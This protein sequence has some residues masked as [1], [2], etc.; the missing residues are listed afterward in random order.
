MTRKLLPHL[1]PHLILLM[2]ICGFMAGEIR[3][4]RIVAWF[5]LLAVILDVFIDPHARNRAG[6]LADV[7]AGNSLVWTLL[8]WSMVPL[9]LA[10]VI[11]GLMLVTREQLTAYELVMVTVSIGFTGAMFSIPV[12]HELMHRTSW[13]DRASAVII[14]TMFSYT[15]FCIEHVYGHHRNVGTAEDTATARF[16]ESF[17]AFYHRAI[18]DGLI[19]AWRLEAIRL[20]RLGLPVFGFRN[21][22]LRY[23]S[24]IVLVYG[25]VASIFG[26]IGVVFL[27][28]Q[29]V[30]GFST[31]EVLNYVQHYGLMRRKT[32][33][34]KYE[35]I[36][37]IHSWNSD[38]RI[39]NW[40]LFNLPR[41]P[42]HHRHANKSYQLLRHVDDAPQ[43]PIGYFAIFWLPL[44]PPLW[45]RIMDPKVEAWRREHGIEF[46]T[47]SL[48]EMR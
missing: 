7:K 23:F 35:R 12:A 45:R 16:G 42:D 6:T 11:S 33:T 30:I 15:H 20:R 44:F 40:L 26:W 1:S 10:L 9:Q 39:S 29:S 41:H 18:P 34:G 19:N 37:P 13:Y 32:T 24:I 46:D 21:R 38:H 4:Y 14:M 22:M 17:Y 43:L 3:V 47:R 28:L 36:R 25:A 48:G 27:S 5:W 2:L 31:L 8:L